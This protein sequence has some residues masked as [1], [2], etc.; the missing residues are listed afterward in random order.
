M[1][2]CV[3]EVFLSAPDDDVYDARYFYFTMINGAWQG[4]C[5]CGIARDVMEPK[6]QDY[7]EFTKNIKR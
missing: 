5:L 7:K 2:A 1:D 4:H 3:R 6:I